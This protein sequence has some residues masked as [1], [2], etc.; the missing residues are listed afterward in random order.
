M[1]GATRSMY[2]A[3]VAAIFLSF[4]AMLVGGTMTAWELV[5][6]AFGTGASI[7]IAKWGIVVFVVGAGVWFLTKCVRVRIVEGDE[8][9]ENEEDLM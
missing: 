7:E 4:A 6:L 3:W 5:K 2:V 8:P 9:E 1:G